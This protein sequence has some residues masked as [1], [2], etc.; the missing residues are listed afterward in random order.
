[1]TLSPIHPNYWV[2]YYRPILRLGIPI[3]IGQ[4]GVIIMG[5]ADTM[6]VGQFSTQAL[7]AAS[8]ANAVFNLI[9]YMLMGYSYG[10]TDRKSVV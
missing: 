6:M 1:M 9:T 8:F 3:A 5:F 10:I 7:A 4:I 2:T